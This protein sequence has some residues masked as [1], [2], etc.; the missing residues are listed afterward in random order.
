MTDNIT[1]TVPAR[2]RR[3]RIEW[4]RVLAPHEYVLLDKMLFQSN[5]T[6]ANKGQ[7]FKFHVRK[8]AA[9]TGISE[10]KVS[11][12]ISG[13]PFV[14][15]QGKTKA[16]TIQLDYSAFETWIA[17]RM[18]NDCSPHEPRNIT[19]EG[20][21][22]NNSTV[23][24][25]FVH[26]LNNPNE[27]EPSE[28]RVEPSEAQAI[29]VVNGAKPPVT[30]GQNPIVHQM[31]NNNAPRYIASDKD[32][33]PLQMPSHIKPGPSAARQAEILRQ[34]KKVGGSFVKDTAMGT[35]RDGFKFAAIDD[36]AKY[37][38]ITADDKSYLDNPKVQTMCGYFRA[39]QYGVLLWTENDQSIF[40]VVKE[41]QSPVATS[42]ASIQGSAGGGT[43]TMTNKNSTGQC[44]TPTAGT[45]GNPEA[46]KKCDL[47]AAFEDLERT[48]QQQA[49]NP[50][51][52]E[53]Q[54]QPVTKPNHSG[55]SGEDDLSGFNPDA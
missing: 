3:T 32:P 14:T 25:G 4:M 49:P 12:I 53:I 21:T 13:W 10:G 22:R 5:L 33:M 26:P 34:L 44:N 55:I 42:A 45:A 39:R 27:N 36:K 30:E 50:L 23:P 18:N 40:E 51:M 8:L 16:M 46:V 52:K 31:N 47:K 54:S 11:E 9:E 43:A 29:P 35:E 15:K 6:D 38:L 24:H 17:H 20:T 2:M 48:F 19:E 1:P 37:V 28:A 41:R 7:G